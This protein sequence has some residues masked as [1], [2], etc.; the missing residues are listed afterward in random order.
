MSFPDNITIMH[1]LI[2]KPDYTS[3][4]IHLEAVVYSGQHQRAAARFV[5]DIAVY[6]YRAGKKTPLLPFMVD[7]LQR[8]YELQETGREEAEKQILSLE[9]FL[10][11]LK[12]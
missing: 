7:E 6:D 11:G 12:K 2:V 1:R 4:R 9:T 10:D 3:D 5:E 8:L